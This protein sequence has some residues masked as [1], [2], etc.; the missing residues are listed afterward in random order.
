[1]ANRSD[2]S[3]TIYT[4]RLLRQVP[5]FRAIVRAAECRLFADI[6]LPEPVLDI[7]TGDGT[8][9]YALGRTSWIG[10]DPASRPAMEAAQLGAYRD[11]AIAVG[12][13]LPFRDGVFGSVISNS[14]LEHIPDVD[15]VIREMYRV[16]RPG[17]TF[18]V[19][20]PSEMFYDYHF[21]TTTLSWLRLKPL[22]QLYRRWVKLTA[23]V[24]HADAANVWRERF[25]RAGLT[26]EDWR[27]YYSRANTCWMDIG[28]YLSAPSLVTRALLGRWVL[29][30]D[31]V[32][33]LPIS[34]LIGPLTRPGV[35]DQGSCLLFVCR[36]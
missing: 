8:F 20:F 11:M 18:A 17:G 31:K 5:F 4:D 10:I 2:S 3:E 15:P 12:S 34:R 1:M 14:T 9:P 27:Y 19:S 29:W 21:G 26:V 24:H 23:R 13:P 36:K 25:E 22:A 28:H 6:N 35:P 32:D 7:G 30:R 33:I 16:L